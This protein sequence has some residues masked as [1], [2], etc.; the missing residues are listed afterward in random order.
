MSDD[1]V[2]VIVPFSLLAAWLGTW[3][4][5][6]WTRQRRRSV[7]L[8]QSARW[9]EVEGK[10]QNSKVVWAHVAIAYEYNPPNGRQIGTYDVGLPMVPFGGLMVVSYLKDR[11]K[12]IMADFPPGQK[13]AVRYNPQNPAESIL[14]RKRQ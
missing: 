10:V 5:Y 7:L 11:T 4:L 3:A 1:T 6:R 2:A 14:V 13:V 9:P 12:L 8:E